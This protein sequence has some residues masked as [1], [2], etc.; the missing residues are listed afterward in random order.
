MRRAFVAASL[1]LSLGAQRAWGTGPPAPDCRWLQTF[2]PP[3]SGFGP[4]TVVRTPNPNG[5]GGCRV[6]RRDVG[7]LREDLNLNTSAAPVNR[8]NYTFC[9][10]NM[11]C[12]YWTCNN[13]MPVR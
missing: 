5:A 7:N 6:T 3:G 2:L 10:N 12:Q 11:P 4:G 8:W 1:L 9:K 13:G